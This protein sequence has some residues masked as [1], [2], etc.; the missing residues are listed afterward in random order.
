MSLLYDL[1]MV[2]LILPVQYLGFFPPQRFPV[3]PFSKYSINSSCYQFKHQKK[4]LGF[5]ERTIYFKIRKK[6]NIF[7]VNLQYHSPVLSEIISDIGRFPIDRKV[8]QPFQAG[9]RLQQLHWQ[10]SPGCQGDI[11]E[12]KQLGIVSKNT[13]GPKIN[14]N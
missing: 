11:L 5:L 2:K 9:Q 13:Q 6:K 12:D 8:P 3:Q 4:M 10:R 1:Q 14:T 7:R